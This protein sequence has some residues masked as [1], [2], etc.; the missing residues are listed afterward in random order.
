VRRAGA[1]A[2]VA[3]FLPIGGCGGGG[4]V[5]R[6]LLLVGIDGAEWSVIEP[7]IEEGRLPTLARLI[8]SGVSCGLRSLEPNEKSPTI[9]TTIATGKLPDKHGIGGYLDP[10]SGKLATSNIRKAR[11]VWDI[12]GEKGWTVTVVGWLVTWPAEPLNGYMVT[13]YFRHSPA[14]GGPPIEQLTYPDELFSEIA[15]LLVSPR[16]VSQADVTRFADPGA[17]MSADEAQ[18]LPVPEMLLE[19]SGL[20]AAEAMVDALRDLQAGDRTFLAVARYLMR[21]RR[22]DV[23]LVYLRGVDTASHRFWAAAHRGEVGFPVS[24]TEE[25]IFGGVVERYYEYA[26]EMLQGLLTDFGDGGTVIVCSDHGFEGPRPGRLPGGIRD[27]GP[28]GILIMA[29]KDIRKGF[30]I[31]E[32]SVC[33]VTPTILALYGLPVG[34]DMDGTAIEG[35]FT[36]RFLRD[37]PPHFGASYEATE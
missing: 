10:G 33:D 24:R 36:D 27:H 19:M 35:A 30:R 6:R 26:D 21:G 14:P 1:L 17:A 15:P 22:T 13:D 12:I 32:R 29:G 3:V 9:W 2:V 28:V 5:E 25:S 4:R 37:N 34:E 16:D 7:L 18:C 11:T 20:D 8:E 23:T 31:G